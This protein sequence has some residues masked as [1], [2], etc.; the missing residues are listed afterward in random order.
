MKRI[1]II[2]IYCAIYSN[3]ISFAQTNN[4]NSIFSRAK[5]LY[6]QAQE[7]NDIGQMLALSDRA[8]GIIMSNYPHNDIILEVKYAAEVLPIM[9]FYIKESFQVMAHYKHA[10][11][12]MPNDLYKRLKEQNMAICDTLFYFIDLNQ[13]IKFMWDNSIDKEYVY[14][15]RGRAKFFLGIST[16][17]NDMNLAGTNGRDFLR[18][19]GM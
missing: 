17:I 14:F 6:A 16:Y 12:P 10:G 8:I 3:L 9:I 13:E 19:W 11:K 5:G 2:T 1:L 4:E 15:L 7:S 18:A